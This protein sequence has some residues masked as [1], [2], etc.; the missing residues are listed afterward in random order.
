M[1][2]LCRIAGFILPLISHAAPQTWTIANDQISRTMTF[3]PAQGLYTERLS[4]LATHADFILPDKLRLNIAP[5]FSFHCN[6]RSYNGASADFELL[7]A[8]EKALAQ[9]KSLTV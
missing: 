2:T 4:D 8:E 1:R 3:T 5:E 9:G 6:G 7:G